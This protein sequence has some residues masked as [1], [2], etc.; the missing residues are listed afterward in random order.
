M[1]RKSKYGVVG[2]TLRQRKLPVKDEPAT[3]YG[4][5]IEI[6]CEWLDADGKCLHMGR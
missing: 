3:P 2:A 5:R 4:V 1:C 6:P